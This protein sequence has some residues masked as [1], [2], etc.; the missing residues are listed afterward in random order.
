M[1]CGPW[2]GVPVV[3]GAGT[4]WAEMAEGKEAPVI[5]ELF[6]F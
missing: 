2:T 3:R 5:M 6:T 1:V 4:G